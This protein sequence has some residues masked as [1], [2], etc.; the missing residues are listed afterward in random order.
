[1]SGPLVVLVGPMGVGKSTVG[2]LLAERLG[3]AY[4][5]T[6]EDIV[7]EQGR[8]IAEIFADDG[9]CAFRAIE[10]RAVAR[11]LA[12]HDGVLALGGGAVLDPRT[13]ALLSGR[14]VVFLDADAGEAVRRIGRDPGRP[15]LAGDPHR[16]WRA[17]AAAR[18]PLYT[19]VARA[20]VVTGGRTPEGVVEAVLAAL[21]P[22]EMKA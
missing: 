8:T 3:V 9:E 12:G 22:R 17:L 16:R 15:L 20:V 4:R 6:D 19:E 10:A 14:P 5:D 21:A 13:R 11:A 1:M 7:A 18:R 2:R